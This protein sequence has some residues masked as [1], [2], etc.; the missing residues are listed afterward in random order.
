MT[1]DADPY[2]AAY[3]RERAARL[4]AEELLET[5]SRE[6]YLQNK[7]LQES[8]QKLQ[9][10]QDYLIQHEKLATLGTLSAGIAHD[11]NNPLSFVSSN[12]S[13]L[14][15]YNETFIKL[16]T[17]I[18]DLIN[19]DKIPSDIKQMLKQQIVDDDL[20]FIEEDLPGLFHDTI[21]GLDRIRAIIDSMRLFSR[22]QTGERNN[23]DIVSGIESTLKL[24]QSQLAKCSN[25]QLQLDLNP[26]PVINCNIQ[27]LNQVFMNLIINASHAVETE[28]KPIIKVKTE[29][30]DDYITI[31]IIDNGT[32]IPPDMA[33]D[34]FTPFFTTKPSGKGTGL[35]LP[36]SRSI[37]EHHQGTLELK[38]KQGTGTAF[39]IKLPIN[40]EE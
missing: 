30:N 17:T 10:Q 27:E 29:H 36:I 39:K 5:K 23:A 13:A 15:T 1:N 26:T 9:A 18:N 28:Q 4:K 21:D 7:Q 3:L 35:G 20:S 33:E 11:I 40:I 14:S 32:G 22:S 12:L 31:S 38:T 24:L 34:I 19:S 8:Y 6:V 2:K 37:I 16:I 25:L